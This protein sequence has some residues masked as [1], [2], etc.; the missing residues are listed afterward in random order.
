MQ[1]A[2]TTRTEALPEAYQQSAAN[3]GSFFAR[4]MEEN[5][6]RAEGVPPSQGGKYVGF[7][8]TPPPPAKSNNTGVSE[9]TGM[10]SSGWSRFATAATAAAAQAT[11]TVSTTARNLDDS[12][13]SGAMAASVQ[14]GA[15]Q[16]Y[17]TAQQLGQS[18]WGMNA[19]IAGTAGGRSGGQEGG[20]AGGSGSAEGWGGHHG[21]DSPGDVTA[22]A[23]QTNGSAGW[24]K[25]AMMAE[26]PVPWAGAGGEEV[27][28]VPVAS[29]SP[30]KG[31][32]ITRQR[33]SAGDLK[34]RSNGWDDDW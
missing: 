9:I 17:S 22:A 30:S 25:P 14:D 10:L 19:S 20:A 28:A 29:P 24:G 1:E 11:T 4:K 23:P 32:T 16:V 7:G 21:F 26:S 12:Y 3:K 13:R 33:G 6:S 18:G 34:K 5:A 15:S 8:S 31:A 2:G 27:A